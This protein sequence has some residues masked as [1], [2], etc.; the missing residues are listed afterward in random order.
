MFVPR[1]Q[2]LSDLL[3]DDVSQDSGL[4]RRQV[5]DALKK[6]ASEAVLMKVGDEFRIQTTAG[7]EWDRSFREERTALA[8]S[9]VEVA[10]ARARALRKAVQKVVSRVRLVQGESKVARKLTLHAGQ[11]SPPSGPGDSVAVWLRDEWS[12]HWRDA[13]NAAREA[14]I[15]DPVLHVHLPKR[16]ANEL[17]N[18]LLDEQAARRVLDKRGVQ[19]SP[20]GQEA[21]ESMQS[22]LARAEGGAQRNCRGDAR[23]RE[24]FSGRRAPSYSKA[25]CGRIWKRAPRRRWRDSFP[26]SP[27]LT[28]G[29][30]E[31][32]SNEPSRVRTNR[33]EPWGGTRRRRITRFPKRFCASLATA[34]NGRS[35]RKDLTA[36]PFGWP[37]DAIDAVLV[38]L[39]QNDVLA[40][41]SDGRRV[42]AL[43]LTQREIGKTRFRPERVQVTTTQRI[44]IRG[45]LKKARISAK[46]RED[47]KGAHKLLEA[48]RGLAEKAGGPAPLPRKPDTKLLDELSALAGNERLAKL[49]EQRDKLE[50]LLEEWDR[51]GRLAARRMPGWELACALC[52]HAKDLS[53][54]QEASVELGA[55]KKG[56]SLL[57]DP[58]VTGPCT[59]KLATVLRQQLNDHFR[60]LTKAVERAVGQLNQDETWRQLDAGEQE[61]VL[62][63]TGLLPP[64]P[65]SVGTNEDVK[66]AL[67]QSSLETWQAKVD[68]GAFAR[69]QGLGRSAKESEG[70]TGGYERHRPAG[71]PER[72]S[73]RPRLGR[74]A[75]AQVAAS[76]SGRAVG[77][78]EVKLAGDQIQKQRY[79]VLDM[80]R[81]GRQD[82]PKLNV[83]SLYRQVG[84]EPVREA[85]GAGDR[86]GPR[87]VWGPR[88]CRG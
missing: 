28:T 11:D 35:V 14:G 32:R 1:A 71:H 85:L 8:R 45:L 52:D 57:K 38:A 2:T 77:N 75:P 17:R 60:R 81:L 56:R 3:V 33:F 20:E 44:A 69:E 46:P 10:A 19:T 40:G 7:V 50:R 76:R 15:E 55:V 84:G 30:G 16:S 37:Q 47:E 13:E 23:R 68:G 72:R 54:G 83:V 67:D 25:V 9:E 66:R 82:L 6:L 49:Y 61:A 64:T 29:R 74:R 86:R 51:L 79:H 26:G 18:H 65:P 27:K 59:V 53:V 12:C 63:Q 4:F 80:Q 21:R 73:G 24:S 87:P 39:L 22:R 70:G 43:G 88:P 62:R 41:T 48:M 34:R 58:D 5:S 36:A 78:R 31:R 42:D